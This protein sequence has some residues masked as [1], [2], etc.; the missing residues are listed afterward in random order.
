M[1]QIPQHLQLDYDSLS[2][3][4][5]DKFNI[6]AQWGSA[7]GPGNTIITDASFANIFKIVKQMGED[8][9]TPIE[10]DR[11]VNHDWTFNPKS[12]I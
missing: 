12:K 2:Y 9:I 6:L 4:Q 7:G 5:K 11:T 1:F 8:P 10:P 3:I